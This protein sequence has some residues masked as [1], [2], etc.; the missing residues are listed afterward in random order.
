MKSGTSIST[1]LLAGG[2]LI[3]CN[4]PGKAAAPSEPD[5]AHIEAREAARM[6]DYG[7]AQKA[8]YVARMQADLAAMEADLARLGTR[9][10]G[11]QDTMKRKAAMEV[12]Q[13]KWATAKLNL[14]LARN[15]TEASWDG[16]KV[17]FKQSYGD[18]KDS[19]DDARTWMSE[20]VAP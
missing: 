10:D 8:E 14:E 17:G 9:V 7:Y 4:Q 1:Y 16:V 12:L 6:Q 3:G 18:L 13:A 20:Q 11:R 19:L 15:A 2:L 5:T